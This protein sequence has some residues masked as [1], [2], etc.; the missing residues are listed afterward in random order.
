MSRSIELLKRRYLE[1]LKDSSSLFVGIELEYPVANLEGRA[2]DIKIVL[3][4][5]RYLISTLNF[6]IEKVDD[7]ENPIQLVEPISQ[8]RIVFEVSYTTIEFAFARAESI[9]E[10]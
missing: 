8:D 3:D 1:N 7:F 6:T 2:T 10:V 4:L 9:Q 5:M